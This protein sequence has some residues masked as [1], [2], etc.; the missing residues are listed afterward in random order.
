MSCETEAQ[1]TFTF[2]FTVS[3]TYGI[4]TPHSSSNA[5][6]V[7]N[8]LSIKKMLQG[9]KC[10]PNLHAPFPHRVMEDGVW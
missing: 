1:P 3:F 4:F 6:A 8:Y 9:M 5:M 7:C 2:H 10:E